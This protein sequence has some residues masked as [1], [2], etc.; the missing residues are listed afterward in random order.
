[1]TLNEADDQRWK[2]ILQDLQV[3]ST[4]INLAAQAELRAAR[5]ICD[6]GSPESSQ[7]L[8][9]LEASAQAMLRCQE[10]IENILALAEGH[11]KAKAN[12]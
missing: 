12:A 9:E 2:L 10:P 3:L 8:N 11:F 5:M 4:Q 6:A 1:M 7:A